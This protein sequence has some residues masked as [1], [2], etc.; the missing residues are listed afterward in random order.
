MR[1]PMKAATDSEGKRP[2]IPIESGH[3]AGLGAKRRRG[4]VHL[5]SFVL[6]FPLADKG[7]LCFRMDSPFSVMAW[8]L[9]TSRSNMASARVGSPRYSCQL[10]TG[11]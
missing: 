1:I 3:F 11:S 4:V 8:A 9:W 6:V 5:V 10:A 7:L 2:A